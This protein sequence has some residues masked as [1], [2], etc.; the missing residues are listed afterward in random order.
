MSERSE[1]LRSL[2]G[3]SL[4]SLRGKRLR[5]LRGR[6]L[7]SLRGR[8]L[9]SLRGRSSD[10]PYDVGK[11]AGRQGHGQGRGGARRKGIGEAFLEK[12]QKDIS[13]KHSRLTKQ[14]HVKCGI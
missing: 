12:I 2:G 11:E 4:K 8:S 7:R 9:R 1:S 10:Q 13:W 14:I 5:S 6:S 3:R